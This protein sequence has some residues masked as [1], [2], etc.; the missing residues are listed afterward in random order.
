MTPLDDGAAAVAGSEEGCLGL[1]PTPR[2]ARGPR[3]TFAGIDLSGVWGMEG[4]VSVLVSSG[5]GTESVTPE[6]EEGPAGARGRETKSIL[7][8]ESG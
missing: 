4:L 1:K 6:T 3:G 2:E 8:V 7:P 5:F